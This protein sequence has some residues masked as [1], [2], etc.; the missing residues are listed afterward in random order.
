[1]ELFLP[2]TKIQPATLICLRSY[3]Y[4]PVKMVGRYG[5]SKYFKQR[6]E[7]KEDFINVE[8]DSVLWPGAIESL[9]KCGEPW[10]AFDYSS[11]TN[12]KWEN[13]VGILHSAQMGCMKITKELIDKTPGIWDKGINW[14]YCDI[15][16][17][18]EAKKVGI[19][20]HQHFPG[21][22]NANPVMLQSRR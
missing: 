7:E 21:I 4:E 14:R 10:C 15:H 3:D 2:Y 17:F 1:M 20:P 6:W 13:E 9:Q 5:Y 22:V 11:I 12:W 8:H 16:L 18:N 19:V